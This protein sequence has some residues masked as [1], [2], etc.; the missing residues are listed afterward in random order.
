MVAILGFTR[1]QIFKAVQQMYTEVATSPAKVFHFPT[2]RSACLLVG[3][4]AAQLDPIPETAIES[5]AGVG[6]PF[7]AGVIGPGACVLDIGSGAGTDALI[8]ARLVGA[9][10]KVWALDM[11]PAMLEKLR[12]NV[13]HA[14]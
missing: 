14:G 10:G 12:G 5:F 2:G 3:Y 9:S 11:T 7:R 6:Y 4:P 13:A 8:A 1:D